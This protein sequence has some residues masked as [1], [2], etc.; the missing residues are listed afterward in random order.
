MGGDECSGE[1]G[2]DLD[3]LSLHGTIQAQFEPMELRHTL[4]RERDFYLFCDESVSKGDFYSNFYGGVLVG[5]SRYEAIRDSLELKKEEL[6]FGKECKWC[7]VGPRYLEQYKQLI[8]EFFRYLQSGEAKVRI[9]FTQN[10]NEPMLTDE[11][12]NEGFNKLYYQFLKHAFG[13][14]YMPNAA[15]ER[16]LRLHL[17]ELPDKKHESRRVFKRHLASFPRRIKDR[18]TGLRVLPQDIAEVDSKKHVLLQCADIV[19]GSMAFRL[20]DLHRAIPEGKRRRGKRTVAKEKLY[21]HI[22]SEICQ[23]R[24]SFNIGISTGHEIK[25]DDRW[26]H[27]YRHW[28]MVPINSRL[29]TDRSKRSGNKKSPTRPT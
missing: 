15:D 3:S 26:N 28:K 19:L 11:D 20:N 14:Q 4:H 21:K 29:N 22:H 16:F 6:G 7:K 24:P 2:A 5:G 10:I 9:M 17:D 23:L 18:T 1:E 25:P 13:F 27:P 12:K 8:S